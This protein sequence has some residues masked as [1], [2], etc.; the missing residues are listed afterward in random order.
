MKTVFILSL[1]CLST[2]ASYGQYTILPK[3]IGEE[4]LVYETERIFHLRAHSNGLSLGYSVGDIETYYKTRYYFFDIGSLKN[5][6][7]YSQNFRFF[8][9][10]LGEASRS[11]IYGKINRLYALRA[12]VGHKKYFSERARRKSV[13][14]GINYEYGFTIGVLKPYYLKLKRSTD[15]NLYDDITE[16]KY[17]EG[18]A[19]IFL[20]ETAIHGGAEFR[21][22]WD[23]IKLK[24]GFHAQFGTNFTWGNQDNLIKA[25]EVGL[26][27]DVFLSKVPLMLT[28]QN[29]P[30][31]IN[32]YLTLQF[33]KRS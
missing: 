7:E 1:F 20:D 6:K 2:I 22:G 19:D 13:I 18:N 5:S 15:G 14:V 33:G 28:A 11:F 4:S 9:S 32:V 30:Y 3:P 26:M 27:A 31:F 24:P 8:T 21:Y 23:E 12:G 17:S 16:E 29:K 10:N 25:L